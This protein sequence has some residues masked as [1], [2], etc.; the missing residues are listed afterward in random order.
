M[1]LWQKLSLLTVCVLLLTG[2]VSGGVVIHGVM[3]Y[4]QSK[5]M[6]N[7]EQQIKSTAFALGR[8][9]QSSPFESYQKATKISYLKYLIRRYDASEYI[10]I[11][12]DHV[13]CNETAF[14]LTDPSDARWGGETVFSVIQQNG[15]QYIL[16]AGK[17]IP[18]GNISTNLKL[19]LVKDISSLYQNIRSQAFFYVLIYLSMIIVAVVLVFIITGRILK[20]L[21]ELQ[22]AAQDIQK[23]NLTRRADVHSKDEMGMMAQAF[24]KMAQRIENQVTELENESERRRQMMGSLAHELKTPMTSIIGYSDSLLHVNLKETQR[25]RALNHIYEQCK[26]LERLS[27]KL[28]SLIGMY[29]NDSIC[30]EELPVQVLFEQA[31]LIEKYNLEQQKIKLVYSC[32]M[33]SRKLDKDLMISLLVNL[34]DNAAK[35]SDVG[36]TIYLT[37]KDNVIAV[38]DEGCGIPEE[39]IEHVTEAFYMVDK[40]RSRKA[41]GSGLGLA[42]CSKI[43]ELHGARLLIESRTGEGTTVLIKFAPLGE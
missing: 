10:L 9:L 27:G 35:A 22:R 7:Y 43:A 20:P 1:K 31:A 5:T 17:R 33:G 25:T 8:E 28:M 36:S 15:S 30:F 24:N 6:E 2:I 38:R 4:N 19:V 41:G 23:G 26:R 32:E 40:A 21:R 39:E 14:H 37:G 3:I 18:L 34:I 42:L 13:I 29:D 11:E 16:L 12:D